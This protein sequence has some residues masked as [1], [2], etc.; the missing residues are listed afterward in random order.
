MTTI[1][2]YLPI[3]FLIARRAFVRSAFDGIADRTLAQK[4]RSTFDG[5]F[6]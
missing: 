2:P 3:A 6:D 4:T 1:R 5:G